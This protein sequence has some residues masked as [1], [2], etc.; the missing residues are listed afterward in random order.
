MNLRPNTHYA[1]KYLV[2][3]PIFPFSLSFLVIL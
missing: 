1:T 2:H 3:S